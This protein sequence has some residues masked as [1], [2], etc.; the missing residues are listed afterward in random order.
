MNLKAL[1]FFVIHRVED[2]DASIEVDGII[3]TTID[4]SENKN[5][6]VVVKDYSDRQIKIFHKSF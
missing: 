4:K 1:P 5:E 2:L 6:G 3:W